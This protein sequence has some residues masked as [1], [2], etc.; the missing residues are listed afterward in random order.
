MGDINVIYS[1]TFSDC[2]NLI[3]ILFALN[4]TIGAGAFRNC[5]FKSLS[6]LDYVQTM[7]IPMDYGGIYNIDAQAF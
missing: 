4:T 3:N 1:S 6:L 2:N 7:D 5:G